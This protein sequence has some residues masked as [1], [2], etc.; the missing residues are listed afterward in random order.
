MPTFAIIN[1]S[2]TNGFVSQIIFADTLDDA[3]QIAISQGFGTFCIEYDQYSLDAPKL[4][5]VW[6]GIKFT[7]PSQIP[8][9][10]ATVNE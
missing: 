5:D 1:G 9:L 2:E 7:S 6:D 8:D 4:G 3:T 10:G